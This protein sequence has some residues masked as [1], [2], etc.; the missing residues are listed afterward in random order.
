MAFDPKAFIDETNQMAQ[1]AT[2]EPAAGQGGYDPKAFIE[3]TRQMLP[4]YEQQGTGESRT[5]RTWQTGQTEQPGAGGS[6]TGM[7]GRTGQT[8]QPSVMQQAVDRK[9]EYYRRR[10]ADY[11]GKLMPMAAKQLDMGDYK[12]IDAGPAAA[13][14]QE[15]M[16]QV[17]AADMPL[18][19]VPDYA[20]AIGKEFKDTYNDAVRGFEDFATSLV[21]ASAMA[22]KATGQSELA[23][24]MTADQR[25]MRQYKT[26]EDTNMPTGTGDSSANQLTHSFFRMLPSFAIGATTGLY[27]LPLYAMQGAGDLYDTMD[28]KGIDPKLSI[29][30]SMTGGLLYGLVEDAQLTQAIPGVKTVLPQLI[31]KASQ[32]GILKAALGGA[33]KLENT[34]LRT[35]VRMGG[36]A[37]GTL[38]KLG[39]ETFKESSEESVQEA[40]MVAAEYMAKGLNDYVHKTN[41][42]AENDFKHVELPRILEQFTSSVG[43]MAALSVFGM[44]GSRIAKQLAWKQQQRQDDTLQAVDKPIFYEQAKANLRELNK[45]GKLDDAGIEALA[46]H[47]AAGNLTYRDI[48]TGTPETWNRLI[49]FNKGEPVNL[50]EPVGQQP[51]DSLNALIPEENRITPEASGQAGQVESETSEQPLTEQ[52]QAELEQLQKGEMFPE[53]SGSGQARQVES[54]TSEQ[55]VPDQIPIGEGIQQPEVRSQESEA[56]ASLVDAR[57]IEQPVQQE[58]ANN[59]LIP[60]WMKQGGQQPEAETG[61][62]G[63]DGLGGQVRQQPPVP[64][65]INK[66]QFAGWT[67]AVLRRRRSR[68]AITAKT[69]PDSPKAQEWNEQ[70]AAIDAETQRR[71]EVGAQEKQDFETKVATANQQ[72]AAI[73]AQ[74][75]EQIQN[76]GDTGAVSRGDTVYPA[77]TP[78]AGHKLDVVY[79][80]GDVNELI[81]SDSPQFDQSLQPR[82]RANNVHSDEQIQKIKSALDPERLMQSYS[83]AEGAPTVDGRKQIISGNGRHKALTQVYGSAEHAV[84]A[85]NYR[86]AVFN[87]AKE[88]GIAVPE[89]IKN[90]VLYR[91][92]VNANG[93][94]LQDIA[95]DSNSS[96][97]LEKTVSEHA[98]SDAAKLAADNGR[99][100]KMFSPGEDGNMFVRGNGDFLN[101]FVHATGANEL[102]NKDGSFNPGA[103]DRI[104]NAMLAALFHGQDG[105]RE[106][107]DKLLELSGSKTNNVSNILD[108]VMT[109]AGKI[110][111]AGENKGYGIEPELLEAMRTIAEYKQQTEFK[112]FDVFL[113]QQD[114]FSGRN[115]ESDAIARALIARQAKPAAV[116][117]FFSRYDELAHA[118]QQMP[119]DMFGGEP[120]NKETLLNTAAGSQ[121]SGVRSQNGTA[122]G[123]SE[124]SKKSEKSEQ[125]GTAAEGPSEKSETSKKSEQ[126]GKSDRADQSDKSDTKPGTAKPAALQEVE[127][128]INARLEYPVTLKAFDPT[129]GSAR[130]RE[131]VE[132]ADSL[133][134]VFKVKYFFYEPSR[135]AGFSG[136]SYQGAAFID[137]S[138]THQAPD[139]L[140]TIVHESVHVLQKKHPELWNRFSANLEELAGQARFDGWMKNR[141]AK[142]EAVG[143]FDADD[144]ALREEFAAEMIADQSTNPEF[145]S[146]LDGIDATLARKILE[147]LKEIL[148]RITGAKIESEDNTFSEIFGDNLRAAIKAGEDFLAEAARE[149]RSQ[150]GTAEGTS[151]KSET[152][153]KSERPFERAQRKREMAKTAGSQESEV[154]SQNKTEQ[155]VNRD[156]QDKQDRI[157]PERPVERAQRKRQQLKQEAANGEVQGTGQKEVSSQ[158]NNL[159]DSAAKPE[160]EQKPDYFLTVTGRQVPVFVMNQQPDLP[161]GREAAF[162]KIIK[163]N[164]SGTVYRLTLVTQPELGPYVFH[165]KGIEQRGSFDGIHVEF[166]KISDSKAENDPWLNRESLKFFKEHEAA[167]NNSD[168]F[169]EKPAAAAPA[170]P[171]RAIQ[172]IQAR[173]RAAQEQNKPESTTADAGAELIAN[174]RGRRT[175]GLNWDEI[176]D[177]NDALKAKE[178]VKANV[179]IKPDY[180]QMVNDGANPAMA[181]LYKTVYDHVAIKPNTRNNPTDADFQLYINA[182]NRIRDGL[183]AWIADKENTAKWLDYLENSDYYAPKTYKILLDYVYPLDQDIDGLGFRSEKIIAGG[184]RMLAALTPGRLDFQKAITETGKGWPSAR[185]KWQIQGLEIHPKSEFRITELKEYPGKAYL[186]FKDRF[187]G[188]KFDSMAEAQS[189]FDA[190]KDFLLT[191]KNGYGVMGSFDTEEQAREGA[192]EQV[193]QKKADGEISEKGISVEAA[194]RTGAERRENGRNVTSEELLNTFGFKGVN[195]GNWM[196]GN[197]N[198]AERQLHLNH[199]YDSFMDL[200]EILNVPPKALA[201][202]GMLGVAVG[203]QGSGKA[204]AHF[205]PG[206]NEINITRTAGAG[207]LA[208]EWGHAI[209]HYFAVLGGMATTDRPF[210]TELSSVNENLRP[211]VQRAFDAISGA[212]KKR[213]QTQA[214]YAAEIEAAR[215]KIAKNIDN[216]LASIRREF[217]RKYAQEKQAEFAGSDI[218]RKFDEISGRIKAGQYGDGYVYASKKVNSFTPG[219]FPA[220]DELR[221]LYS[222]FA[223]RL[224]G[225][226]DIRG[227]QSNLEAMKYKNSLIGAER[228]HIPQTDTTYYKNAKVMDADKTK[229]YWSTGAELFA[230][231]FSAYVNT[232]LDE[233][234]AVNTYITRPGF[235]QEIEVAPQGEEM[236]TIAVAFDVL[237]K[238]LKTKETDKG[239]LLFSLDKETVSEPVAEWGTRFTQFQNKPL[240]AINYLLDKKSGYAE[241]TVYR[242]GLG[243]IDIVYGKTGQGAKD[244][245]GYGLAHILKRHPDI[246]F[247]QMAELLKNGRIIDGHSGNKLIISENSKN[248]IIVM[249]NWKGTLRQWVVSAYG[250]ELENKKG[251]EST[252]RPVP[253]D[254]SSVIAPVRSPAIEV[255][256][257]ENSIQPDSG[258]VK[259]ENFKRWFGDWENDPDNASKVVDENGKPLVV[260]HSSPD[261]FNVFDTSKDGAHFGTLEQARNL[262]KTGKKK[263][264]SYYLSIHNPLRMNDVGVWNDFNGLFSRLYNDDII[265]SEESDYIWSEWQYTDARG[266]QAI[267]DTLNK[268]GYDGIIYQN[269]V[270]GKG[271][272][273]IAFK[274]T[275]I[276]SATSNNGEFDGKNPDIRF[277]LEDDVAA[278]DEEKAVDAELKTA[279]IVEK[280]TPVWRKRYESFVADSSQLSEAVRAADKLATLKNQADELLDG[281]FTLGERSPARKAINR[282]ISNNAPAALLA[283]LTKLHM[284]Y[285][286]NNILNR[287]ENMER[288]ALKL[289]QLLRK[290]S[291]DVK[292]QQ[293]LAYLY[294]KRSLAPELHRKYFNKI[295]KLS[296]F[297]RPETVEKHF[298]EIMKLVEEARNE[299]QKA[300][301]L[302]LAVQSYSDEIARIRNAAKPGRRSDIAASYNDQLLAYLNKFYW[303]AEKTVDA[304]YKKLE[305]GEELTD[306]EDGIMAKKSVYKLDASALRQLL[307]DIQAI[308][309]AGK[310]VQAY[311]DFQRKQ[312]L[313][314]KARIAAMQWDMNPDDLRTPAERHN[315]KYKNGIVRMFD[316]FQKTFSKLAEIMAPEE[317]CEKFSNYNRSGVFYQETFQKL[318]DAQRTEYT[319]HEIRDK[320]MMEIY[321]ELDLE[322]NGHDIRHKPE[323][324]LNVRN[325]GSTEDGRDTWHLT[326]A[327]MMAVYANS[328][329]DLNKK[330]LIET[331]VQE[332]ATPEQAVAAIDYA[333]SQ[334]PQQFKN[335]VDRQIR[336]Y[337]NVVYPRINEVFRDIHGVDMP[338]E[339]HYFPIMFLERLK[340]DDFE[341]LDKGMTWSAANNKGVEKGFTIQRSGAGNAFRNLDYFTTVT[342]NLYATEH[343]I[344]FSKPIFEVRSFL[345]HTMIAKYFDQ[346]GNNTYRS[347]LMRL[348]SDA[349]VG[350][351]EDPV[352]GIGKWMAALRINLGSA[353]LGFNPAT[354]LKQLPTFTSAMP[355][356]DQLEF[357]R[358]MTRMS[359][360]PVETWNFI[361]GKS[362]LM[363]ERGQHL[364]LTVSTVMQRQQTDKLLK[365]QS[366]FHKFRELSFKGIE[367]LDRFVVGG[368]W[369]AVYTK[370]LKTNGGNEAAAVEQADWVVRK[371]QNDSSLI[372]LPDMERRSEVY[373]MFSAFTNQLW[374]QFNLFVRSV[375]FSPNV[376]FKERFGI[377]YG[378]AAGAYF[379]Q[380][381]M[382]GFNFRIPW[383][384]PEEF[385]RYLVEQITGGIPGLNAVSEYFMRQA[386]IMHKTGEGMKIPN[387]YRLAAD[388]KSSFIPQPLEGMAEMVTNITDA[389]EGTIKNGSPK[390]ND[391]NMALRGALTAFGIPG[392]YLFSRPAQ[393]WDKLKETGDPRYLIM[394]K[395]AM[396]PTFQEKPAAANISPFRQRVLDRRR[397]ARERRG[398]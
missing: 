215:T 350:R 273:Y 247:E 380:V 292:E 197:T 200:A 325:P 360:S 45:S 83:I 257:S 383:D 38:A 345:N 288:E 40:V 336:Y 157:K 44:K 196:G 359:H 114:A 185:E 172:R 351:H 216:W 61:A 4:D 238:E 12:I 209:D 79:H 35:G 283:E 252:I 32:Y 112:D 96:N 189:W 93:V 203:A 76:G 321:K 342:T 10:G 30:L 7:T 60:D 212:M 346:S 143:E 376:S 9:N 250:R 308:K 118:P 54:E 226:E 330:H 393:N 307:L 357:T 301:L 284:A 205:V 105:R 364:T 74:H 240:E 6:L 71:A 2:G 102:K 87:K 323:L 113:R 290:A 126:P 260:Y 131:I 145:W 94:S 68:L 23:A 387:G 353:A 344:A 134:E 55:P 207:A 277:S 152:S 188:K 69:N 228:T 108:G 293:K 373:R 213:A 222:D 265:T 88:L 51:V 18:Q 341:L 149:E 241:K 214:E 297:K 210:I 299:H 320:D 248:K 339:D 20:G 340:A 312:A 33:G 84:Q 137:I 171:E 39:M 394:N 144:G 348:V 352:G 224:Y 397:E 191:E 187:S 37:G 362:I 366:T 331:F 249:L 254:G 305:N 372:N 382:K 371:T 231:A 193:K 28:G 349:A 243:W 310:S 8:E 24:N 328:Q 229:K 388:L 115:A 367:M 334:L 42:S 161:K 166:Q 155:P 173:R 234:N 194:E 253:V 266:W 101:A 270:E 392:Y 326:R 379:Q 375:S 107:I 275:Q 355:Y 120:E 91:E 129:A 81:N 244:M 49:Q 235:N 190:Q 230:R 163:R 64:Q 117:E 236:K 182:V 311:N 318:V 135:K 97:V 281:Y 179:W 370:T 21:A 378:L 242:D 56:G 396:E 313:D 75:A 306:A 86:N 258:N 15:Q 98:E 204:A 217:A 395:G 17:N 123:P 294:I 138:G 16:A 70:L 53:E 304:I 282:A 295:I 274:P 1:T 278:A 192:R 302:E 62:V 106:V 198:N 333:I 128:A 261:K 50:L 58:P 153:K 319:N 130:Q 116:S 303:G 141:K 237:F 343:M 103:S 119:G 167:A 99:I 218:E 34:A 384:E 272:S 291:N 368:V 316:S 298:N 276:K 314:R 219:I 125:P 41:M 268:K 48:A 263:P 389:V 89:H 73:K 127:D 211:E 225:I 239:T 110:V 146:K 26:A 338:K 14:N 356:T 169:G 337:D 92:I 122:E 255:A 174:K 221:K 147:I 139:M 90:P 267:K 19:G 154:R 47:I 358:A 208:H 22:A 315:L 63:Q 148:A 223:G 322:K 72:E 363:K 377:F 29:P 398:E 43:P 159:I 245:D 347:V 289:Q 178:T 324:L 317:I 184:Q 160:T 232:K 286:G 181:Y 13:R 66:D 199:L 385:F 151:E 381:I 3:E 271:D 95:H 104:R 25:R 132:F 186:F 133:A 11:S 82:D 5:G 300:E 195:F 365:A 279:P 374:K 332:G 180:E 390:F 121:E 170:Q 142:I 183:D 262:K 158:D 202:N 165:E 156:G 246:D 391:I 67:D 78:K 264:E 162:S 124:T 65:T 59:P 36:K 285:V 168:L 136:I 46:G 329:N 150:D 140:N 220:A 335:A 201:L 206:V 57:K 269:E 164:N 256:P 327:D 280:D 31:E 259:S 27:S 361:A 85:R 176:A 287:A 369:M 354:A 251:S 100:L 111:H 80:I 233:R 177:K 296:D 227:L 109:A 77:V 175:R 52:E 309:Q 386:I